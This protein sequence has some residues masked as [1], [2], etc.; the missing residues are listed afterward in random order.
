MVD[1]TAIRK[2]EYELAIDD[3]IG[4][5]I[6]DATVSISIGQLFFPTAVFVG[7]YQHSLLLV[8][9]TIFTSAIVILTLATK[10][11]VGKKA[12]ILFILLYIASFSLPFIV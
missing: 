3:I 12:G 2:G 4:S 10:R 8:L 6:V 1:V 7:D 9:Y 5:C 11:K